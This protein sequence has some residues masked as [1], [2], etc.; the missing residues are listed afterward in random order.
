MNRELTACIK[1]LLFLIFGLIIASCDNESKK[2]MNKADDK[3][4]DKDAIAFKCK[5]KW[6]DPHEHM[7]FYLLFDKEVDKGLLIKTKG[8]NYVGVN[9]KQK[10]EEYYTLSIAGKSVFPNPMDDW[11]GNERSFL[12]GIKINR[13]TLELEVRR[14]EDTGG[15]IDSWQC[16]KTETEIPLKLVKSINDSRN[17]ELKKLNELNKQKEKEAKF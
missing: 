9:R 13:Q 14:P 4:S 2:P 3:S 10:N 12:N 11:T 17:F 15:S 1:V 7:G 6:S 5:S 8:E 16:E